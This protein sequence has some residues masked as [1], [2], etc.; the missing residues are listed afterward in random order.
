MQDKEDRNLKSSKGKAQSNWSIDSG[1]AS[2]MC[3]ETEAW[4]QQLFIQHDT[5]LPAICDASEQ[6]W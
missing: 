6:A 3:I 2:K 5:K 1:R 4:Q